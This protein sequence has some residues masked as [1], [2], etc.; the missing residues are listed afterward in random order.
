M[1]RI[2]KAF[3]Y[4][5]FDYR[6]F[7]LEK[8]LFV[9]ALLVGIS[10]SF[11]ACVISIVVSSAAVALVTTFGI[12]FTLLIS[13]YFVRVK[14]KFDT[15]IFP[16]ILIS[17]IGIAV[18]WVF[19]G[20][21]NGSNLFPGLVA[22]ILALIIAP[23][24]KKNYVIALF[25]SCVI[26][27]YLIQWFRPDIIVPLAS[28]KIRWFDSLVTVVYSS[29]I[30]SLIVRFLHK[31]YTYERRRAEKN[32]KK[33]KQLNATK[34]KLFSII[35]HD[36]RSPFN[37]ILGLS[38][39]LLENNKND[40]GI[41][42]NQ[43][44]S[45]INSSAKNTLTLLDNLLNWTQVQ[46]GDIEIKSEQTSLSSVLEEVLAILHPSI[47]LKNITINTHSPK[48]III[49]TD[50]RLV[51]TILRNLISNA[52]K[53][54]NQG[55]AIDVSIIVASNQI[56]VTVS[57]NGVGMNQKTLD[58]LFKISTNTTTPGTSNEKGSGLG[59]VLCKEF[60]EK[61]GGTIWAESE[62]GKGSDF[63]FILPNVLSPQTG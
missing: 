11:I 4:I 46:T 33:L 15:F 25:I 10:L 9:T 39:M 57:D 7:P 52:I 20:G 2:K 38:D 59:L 55:G 53:F 28:E 32:A 35:A 30:I 17:I 47:V 60:T 36:L 41:D 27:I 40:I 37:S 48:E 63:K 12:F 49:F 1:G 14:K 22:L 50:E 19:D 21:I 24:G 61:L 31:N 54:T 8:R 23:E 58:Q 56:E 29:F 44:L 26:V 13:Y 51:K 6:V 18:I 62:E 43:Y 34:D 3:N 42:T 5:F 45:L 16:V